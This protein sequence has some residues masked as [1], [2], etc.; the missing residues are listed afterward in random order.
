MDRITTT[1]TMLACLPCQEI[2]NS[3]AFAVMSDQVELHRKCI[4]TPTKPVVTRGDS[5]KGRV[6]FKISCNDLSLRK[7]GN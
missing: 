7:T 4:F 2:N 6:A 3:S 1:Y 5:L